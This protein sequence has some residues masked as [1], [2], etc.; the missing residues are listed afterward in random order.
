MVTV[1][2]ESKFLFKKTKNELTEQMCK[3]LTQFYLHNSK[4]VVEN[5]FFFAKKYFNLTQS[6]QIQV[7]KETKNN[8]TGRGPQAFSL[9]I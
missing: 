2:V 1:C 7:F 9:I 6:S 3:Q 8:E 4:E 5:L